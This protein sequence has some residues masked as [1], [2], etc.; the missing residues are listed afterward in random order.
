MNLQRS[1]LGDWYH[2][3][4]LDDWNDSSIHRRDISGSICGLYIDAHILDAHIFELYI[5]ISIYVYT[6]IYIYYDYFYLDTYLCNYIYCYRYA[7]H[8]HHHRWWMGCFPARIITFLPKLLKKRYK[9]QSFLNVSGPDWEL[10]Q[11]TKK[12]G[13]NLGSHKFHAFQ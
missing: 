1:Q 6:Y 13:T 3:W 11:T 9:F 8:K 10:K 4:W 2:Q 5:Y 12:P 7:T